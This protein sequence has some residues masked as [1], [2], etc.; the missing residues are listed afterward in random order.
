MSGL[1]RRL[2][3]LVVSLSLTLTAPAWAKSTRPLLEGEWKGKHG[4]SEITFIF[5]KADKLTVIQD[6]LTFKGTYKV[7]YDK[8]P[9]ELD[10]NLEREGRI[11]RGLTVIEFISPNEIRMEEPGP[12]RPKDFKK[13][14]V[15]FVRQEK[16]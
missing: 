6:G 15:V 1:S 2:F 14:P 16:K 10:L 4:D 11:S 5:A 13:A 8:V 9:L 7:D 3:V 12:Q